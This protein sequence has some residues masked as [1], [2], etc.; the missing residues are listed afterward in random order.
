[1]KVKQNKTLHLIDLGCCPSCRWTW[2][3]EASQQTFW[4]S[5]NTKKALRILF[6]SMKKI[7]T[8]CTNDCDPHFGI[9]FTLSPP[10]ARSRSCFAL[11]I[12]H[13]SF[14]LLHFILFKRDS[15]HIKLIYVW[16]HPFFTCK[17]KSL[18]PKPIGDENNDMPPMS[19]ICFVISK[20][21]VL[22]FA[23][24]GKLLMS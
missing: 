20:F 7:I 18:V 19:D 5:S 24:Q 14:F 3:R 12:L 2:G 13:Y 9:S 1:M 8:L 11:G 23:I 6:T 22:C 10:A 16:S 17:I 4:A 15:P 21:R